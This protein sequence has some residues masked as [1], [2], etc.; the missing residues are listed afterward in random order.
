MNISKPYDPTAV[1]AKIA[2]IANLPD[3]QSGNQAG[4]PSGNLSGNQSPS[5]LALFD[6]DHTLLPI[7]SDFEWGRFLVRIGILDPAVHEQE[8]QR[9]YRQYQDGTLNIQEYLDYALQPLSKW[10]RAEVDGWH[11]QFMVEV[12]RP[13]IRPEAIDLVRHHQEA[14][15]L[16]AVVTATNAFVTRPIAGAFGIDHLIATEV[17]EHLGAYTGRPTGTPSFREGKV[18]RTLQWLNSLDKTLGTFKRSWFYSD[19]MN[20]L[21]LLRQVTDPVAT[22]PDP[23]LLEAAQASGWPVLRLF[24]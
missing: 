18:T 10:P 20:D 4:N 13:A 6:L 23:R 17:E 3:D 9:F 2:A 8:N 11:A 15:H 14:G 5:G 16:C 19:S 22:N 1:R 7:D 24:E 21:P 12:V